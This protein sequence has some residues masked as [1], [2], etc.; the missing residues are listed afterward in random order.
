MVGNARLGDQSFAKKRQSGSRRI[1]ACRKEETE[2]IRE[3]GGMKGEGKSR[4]RTGWVVCLAR[5]TE[6]GY[7]LSLSLSLSFSQRVR[8]IYYSRLVR[9]FHAGAVVPPSSPRRFQP[10]PFPFVRS[11]KFS[12]FSE[13]VQ[14]H[15]RERTRSLAEID[16]QVPT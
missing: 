1:V 15:P 4:G 9:L 10:S 3:R 7:F 14:R 13:R 2:E 8:L 16:S 12:L 11:L 5:G 6:H